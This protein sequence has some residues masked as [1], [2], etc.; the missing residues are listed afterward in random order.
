MLTFS[1]NLLYNIYSINRILRRNKMNKKLKK[2]I[3]TSI[4]GILMVIALCVLAGVYGI[5]ASESVWGYIAN[6]GSVYI[7]I[8]GLATG[9]VMYKK[10]KYDRMEK[11]VSYHKQKRDLLK[12][13]NEK[14]SFEKLLLR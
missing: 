2:T 14:V 12:P 9:L 7:Y 1:I 10:G 5:F 8:A 11:T 4:Q 13:K 6:F 3:E